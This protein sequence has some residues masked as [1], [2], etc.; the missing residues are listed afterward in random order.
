MGDHVTSPT[1]SDE[2]K[3]PPPAKA[4]KRLIRLGVSLGTIF[5]ITFFFQ[6]AIFSSSGFTRSLMPLAASAT[7]Q[8]AVTDQLAK[9]AAKL[10]PAAPPAVLKLAAAQVVA[11][12]EFTSVWL[13]SETQVHDQVMA[14]MD[15]PGDASPL[16]LTV[17]L[18][19]LTSLLVQRLH[20]NGL[21]I[22]RVITAD[23]SGASVGTISAAQ[24]STMHTVYTLIRVVELGCGILGLLAILTA[25]GISRDRIDSVGLLGRAM[26]LQM[27]I[28]LA[29][30]TLADIK[31]L[32][33]FSASDDTGRLSTILYN[34]FSSQLHLLL[35]IVGAGAIAV[36]VAALIANQARRWQERGLPRQLQGETVR[37]LRTAVTLAGAAVILVLGSPTPMV[38]VDVFATMVGA[39][40]FV[41]YAA[42]LLDVRVGRT[43]ERP[44]LSTV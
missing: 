38:A 13:A 1:T 28:L 40:L 31:V 35:Q 20:D 5:L 44:A 34:S 8:N 16:N 39:L 24:L 25:L 4:P 2:A 11:S 7:L 18:S 19:P 21:P 26:C 32:S 6:Q 12:A 41:T 33:L 17:E 43:A 15:A 30:L 22:A 36:A 27:A 23:L 3:A 37:A 42:R 29:L 14:R 10:E 9:D